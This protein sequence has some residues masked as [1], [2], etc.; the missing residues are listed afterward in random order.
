MAVLMSDGKGKRTEAM[1]GLLIA[2]VLF[3]ALYPYFPSILRT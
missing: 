1:S 3:F 2:T